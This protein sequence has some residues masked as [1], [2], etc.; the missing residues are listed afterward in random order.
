MLGLQQA[1]MFLRLS[2]EH[3][4]SGHAITL[5]S[6]GMAFNLRQLSE[7]INTDKFALEITQEHIRDWANGFASVVF[8]QILGFERVTR[9]EYFDIKPGVYLFDLNSEDTPADL[10][11]SADAVFDLGTSEHVFHLPN[12]L[13]HMHRF[14]KVGSILVHHTPANNHTNHGFYQFA[15]TL[16]RHYYTDNR[17]DIIS[18]YLNG[19]DT[20]TDTKHHFLA[21]DED[22]ANRQFFL[23]DDKLSMNLFLAKKTTRSLCGVIPNQGVYK[24]MLKS[25]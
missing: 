15:P 8:F 19:Y 21:V 4:F 11:D 25:Q 16:Y 5:S 24:A 17:Y 18:Q 10:V 7:V 13:K 1:R 22:F 12:V 3:T 9:L 2:Q 6:Y 20:V 23:T 14:A